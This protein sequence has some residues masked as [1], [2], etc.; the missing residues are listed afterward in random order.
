MKKDKEKVSGG[1]VWGK[2]KRDGGSFISSKHDTHVVMAA[3]YDV[4]DLFD[5]LVDY[6]SRTMNANLP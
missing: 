4:E 2:W 6:K 3:A 5:D 1:K